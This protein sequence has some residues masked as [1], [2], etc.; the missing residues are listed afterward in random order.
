MQETPSSAPVSPAYNYSANWNV[1]GGATEPNHNTPRLRRTAER[2]AI[3]SRNEPPTRMAFRIGH[4]VIH[5]PSDLKREA[6]IR[7]RA[8][9]GLSRC[10]LISSSATRVK[11]GEF[12]S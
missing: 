7:S 10:N 1:R 12:R 3:G 9:P 11:R 4:I 2:M 8:T 5:Q 6:Q